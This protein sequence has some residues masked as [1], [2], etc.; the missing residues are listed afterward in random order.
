MRLGSFWNLA[1]VLMAIALACSRPAGA[2][3]ILLLGE[4]GLG[5]YGGLTD[6]VVSP[7]GHFLYAADGYRG[8]L[9][10]YAR[11]A[12]GRLKEAF[13]IF[14]TGT[15][16][17]FGT[18]VQELM[19]SPDG[20]HL[21]AVTYTSGLI[22]AF[23]RNRSTGALTQIQSLDQSAV[24]EYV[25]GIAISRDGAPLYIASHSRHTVAVFAR[26]A[27][28]GL[29]TFV[30]AQVNG[31]GGVQG[32]EDPIGVAVTPDG[33]GV[34]AASDAPG[35]VVAFRRDPATGRL[36]FV[37]SYG[38]TASVDLGFAFAVAVS[39]DS[40]NV[41]VTRSLGGVV[42]R[43]DPLTNAI[44][45]IQDI[46]GSVDSD[47]W[48]TADGSRAYGCSGASVIGGFARDPA[49]GMLTRDEVYTGSAPEFLPPGFCFGMTISPDGRSIYTIDSYEDPKTD[50]YIYALASFRRAN[51]TCAPAPRTDC[52]ETLHPGASVLSLRK[53]IGSDQRLKWVWN[54]EATRRAAF[55]NPVDGNA[56]Y[57]L[58]LYEAGVPIVHAAAP[59][60]VSCGKDRPCWVSRGASGVAFNDS[61]RRFGTQSM[62]LHATSD[63]RARL[64]VRGAGPHLDLAQRSFTGSITAQLQASVGKHSPCWT[65]TYTA[66]R[67][68]SIVIYRATSD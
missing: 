31:Q 46:N 49:T 38:S 23:A 21:Y 27:S 16:A 62:A 53:G 28:S 36:T 42:Y 13:E 2:S 35:G 57:V 19:I 67:E 64:V 56:D 10:C 65:A 1:T 7:D 52:R 30:E 54:G 61:A 41:Y 25:Q 47:I 50:G 32:L 33:T 55:G 63:G 45:R 37:E 20:A 66:P 26:D 60:T 4:D 48:V 9:S 40:A 59:G 15:E 34:Y 68:N 43:R 22:I 3:D 29:L 24:L 17:P 39:P 58:C 5:E 44:T 8:S 11:S 6:L 18:G 51:L 12:G 14:P